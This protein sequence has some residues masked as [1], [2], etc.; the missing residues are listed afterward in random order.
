MKMPDVSKV[1]EKQGLRTVWVVEGA[2][3][4]VASF[5]IL[6]VW[7]SRMAGLIELIPY[8]FGLIALQGTGAIGGSNFKRLTEGYKLKAENHRAVGPK[9]KSGSEV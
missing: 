7:P 8:L 4:F 2:L 1:G 3:L 5:T 9:K 6:M